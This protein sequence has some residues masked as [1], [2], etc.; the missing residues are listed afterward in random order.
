MHAPPT[1]PPPPV[2]SALGYDDGHTQPALC[3]TLVSNDDD[4]DDD[5]DDDESS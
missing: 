5:N 2:L 1:A 3:L 4:D